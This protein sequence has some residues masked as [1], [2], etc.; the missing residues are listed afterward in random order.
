M[1]K[2]YFM[3]DHPQGFVD[4]KL[5]VKFVD[6]FCFEFAL[7]LT[8]YQEQVKW[9]IVK[10]KIISLSNDAHN[11]QTIQKTKKYSIKYDI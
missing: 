7:L 11:L 10:W 3:K 1:F 8:L 2:N 4:V 6:S 9:K 5:L